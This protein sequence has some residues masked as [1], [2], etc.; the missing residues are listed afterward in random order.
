MYG[1]L[2]NTPYMI[3]NI[4]R[5]RSTPHAGKAMRH[6]EHRRVYGARRMPENSHAYV[7][8]VWVLDVGDSTTTLLYASFSIDVDGLAKSL[9]DMALHTQGTQGAIA[10]QESNLAFAAGIETTR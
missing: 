1:S 5:R 4:D 9:R 10:V 6:S 7:T 8:V 2:Q 3:P